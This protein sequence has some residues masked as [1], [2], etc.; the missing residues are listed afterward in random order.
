M[1]LSGNQYEIAAGGYRA[2][3]TE[4]GG[5]LRELTHEG[6]PLV[7]G[8]APDEVVD[9]AA[10]QILA[11]WPNRI[12]H[13][14]YVFEGVEQHTPITEPDRDCAIHGLVRWE[15]WTVTEHEADR[16]TL[17]HRLL[18]RPGYPY[19]LDLSVTY[20]L[21]ARTGLTVRLG[22]ANAG[23]R[24]APYGQSAHPYLTVGRPL[25]ECTVTFGASHYQPVNER[26][27]PSGAPVPVAGTRYDL[28]SGGVFGARRIDTAYTGLEFADGRA[29][30]GLSGGGRTV[31][32]WADDGH[33]WLQLYTADH[34]GERARTGLAAEP[35]TCPP[36]AFN[37]GVDL[38]TLKPG[39]AF[40][41]SWGIISL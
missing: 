8:F 25:D 22:A 1:M 20:S 40:A 13:G 10:G 11:P 27:I 21:D 19:R 14:T 36:N 35:M 24:N 37:T 9:G 6:A 17:V 33:P 38:I 32:L 23:T 41:S 30:V 2:A 29:W 26:L 39:D 3:A 4:Q 5:S 7:I 34:M 16:V 12:A 28:S 31:G 15:P 18:G